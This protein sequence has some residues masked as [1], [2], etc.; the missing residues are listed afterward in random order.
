MQPKR[1]QKQEIV[2]SYAMRLR[3]LCLVPVFVG[4]GVGG[5]GSLSSSLIACKD[6]INIASTFV[7]VSWG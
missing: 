2:E 1:I 6:V 4:P 7:S 5:D 3:V